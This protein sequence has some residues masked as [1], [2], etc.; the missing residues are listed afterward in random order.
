VKTSRTSENDSPFHEG[1]QEL[2][3]RLGMREKMERFGN[4]II[5]DFMPAQHRDFFNQLPL[6]FV[7][8]ADRDTWPWASIL[9]GPPGFITSD[10]P[11]KLTISTTA[12]PGDPLENFLQQPEKPIQRLGLLGIELST[13]RRNRLSGHIVET[14]KQHI[15]IQVDQAFGN[16]PQYI[17]T[18]SLEYIEKDHAMQPDTTD[19]TKLDTQAIKLIS[20]SDTFFVAS[21]VANGSN[22]ASEGVDVSHRGGKP[23]FIR[24][25]DEFTLTIPDYLGNFHFNTLGNFFVNP[26]A[27]LLFIDFEKG[28]I[29]TIT[30]TVKILWDSPDTKF[31]NGAERLWQFRIDHGHWI[32]NAL[33]LRWKLDEYSPNTE[34]TGTWKEAEQIKELQEAR[35]NWLPYNVENIVNESSVIK[36]FYLKPKNGIPH[37][38]KAGQFLTIKAQVDDKE[39]IRTYTVS[40]A[41]GNEYYRISVKREGVFSRYLHDNIAVGDCIDIKAPCGAFTFDASI[42]R[43][44]VLLA[45]GIGATPMVSMAHHALQEGFRTRTIRPTTLICAARSDSQRAFFEEL[46]NIAQHSNGNIRAFWVLSQIEEKLKPGKDFHHQ[47]RISKELL[48]AIL[49]VDDYDFYLCGPQGF[50]QSIYDILRSL[51]VNNSRIFDEAF[52]NASIVRDETTIEVQTHTHIEKKR[53]EANEAVVTFTDSNVKQAWSKGDGTLLEFAESHGLSP[54]YGCRNGQCGACKTKLISGNITYQHDYTTSLDKDEILLC[55]AVPAES[56]NSDKSKVSIKI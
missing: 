50:M 8:H 41:P 29:L 56:E 15:D 37:Q 47:G 24:V 39:L 43:P 34:L 40:S 35:N 26:K 5:R 31:F 22:E 13:R 33:P 36:S 4:Q 17:Q 20:N 11:K 30:G 51:G 55:C 46:N 18:R 38:F 25:D 48:Q 45:A 16:C 44:A 2:Q 27:G 7:G 10:N 54:A 53:Q 21:Y 28:N 9:Y 49:P 52:G 14:S 23:G 12:I 6:V 42:A 32:R 19:L 3:S 1:E